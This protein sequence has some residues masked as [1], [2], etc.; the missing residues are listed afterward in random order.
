[1]DKWL[2]ILLFIL[3]L[4]L[5]SA[6]PRGGTAVFGKGGVTEAV[7]GNYAAPPEYKTSE[8]FVLYNI[9]IW[10]WF[11]IAL[12]IMGVVIVCFALA[13]WKIIVYVTKFDNRPR[14]DPKVLCPLCVK[15]IKEHAWKHGNHRV[16]CARKYQAKI[17]NEWPIYDQSLV[18]PGCGENLRKINTSSRLFHCQ[19]CPSE[20]IFVGC[21]ICDFHMCQSCL[22]RQ[23]VEAQRRSLISPKMD[24]EPSAPSYDLV[25]SNSASITVHMKNENDDENLDDDEGNLP[26]YEQ[27]IAM[28]KEETQA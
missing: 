24:F 14:T 1:M 9:P 21:Y 16:K 20:S 27:A 6:L 17:H 22:N 4:D 2:L 12:P 28:N 19:L 3:L 8:T 7:F 25:M 11:L 5:A 15:K 26:S 13:V 23:R 10:G 18:C